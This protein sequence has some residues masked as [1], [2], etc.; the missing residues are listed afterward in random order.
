M[1]VK[2]SIERLKKIIE[3]AGEVENYSPAGVGE[4][5]F[6]VKDDLIVNDGKVTFAM[7]EVE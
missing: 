6:E 3:V 4:M 1:K 7:I 5:T 2:V